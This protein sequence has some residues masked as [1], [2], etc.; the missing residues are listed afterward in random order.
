MSE[1][2]DYIR[3]NKE[4]FKGEE[5][6]DG[7]LDRFLRKLEKEEESKRSSGVTFWRVA[8][9]VIVLATISVSVLLPR[10]NSPKD[11]QYAS[12]SLSDVSDDLAEVELYYQSKLEREYAELNSLSETDPVV[13]S[14][15]DELE[16]MNELYQELEEKLYT[17]GSHE[18]V[19]IAMIENFRLRL[20][21][22]EKLE[23]KKAQINDEL[24][25]V[26]PNPW[27]DKVK[28]SR[29]DLKK[30]IKR[31]VKKRRRNFKKLKQTKIKRT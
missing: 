25:L 10:F 3:K 27:K 14:Y 30:K 13:K 1:L 15:L 20:E 5:P 4:K 23:K 22:I 17:S 7:H 2:E 6:T 29:K 26:Q 28:E 18:K 9:A 8:A 16:R 31:K 19:V 12:M 24:G 11:V 21:L